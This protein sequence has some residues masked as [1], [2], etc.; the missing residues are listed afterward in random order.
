MQESTLTQLQ[1]K[2]LELI[3]A[4]REHIDELRRLRQRTIEEVVPDVSNDH[5]LTVNEEK[6]VGELLEDE[7]QCVV[8]WFRFKG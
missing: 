7:G 5:D 4:F 3:T 8:T 1:A 2:R 6:W